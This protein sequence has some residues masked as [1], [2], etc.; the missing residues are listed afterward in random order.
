MAT[1]NNIE[2]RVGVIVLLAIIVLAGSLYWLQGYRLKL[3]SQMMTVRF[4]D[5]GTL[6]VGDKITV[7]G[8]RKGKVDD[9]RLT[10]NGVLVRLQLYQD[11]VLRRD[12]VFTI[13]N[14]GVM[15]DRFVAINP[16]KDSVLYDLNRV[17]EGRYDTG[18]PEVM[19]MMGDM[20]TQLHEL[21]LSLRRTVASD[22]ALRSFNNTVSNLESVSASMVSYVERHQNSF[23]KTAENFVS[24]SRRLDDLLARSDAPVDST[25]KRLDRVSSEVEV[26]VQQ[27]DSVAAAARRFADRVEVEEGTLQMLVEDRSLYDDLRRTADN[28]DDLI[29]D[30]RA[31]PRKYINLKVELF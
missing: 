26:I 29:A 13:K 19:G 22:S 25:L 5:V 6:S 31:N 27:L 14:L 4:D 1:G 15:G 9:L 11:V 20:V 30:I 28:L 21:V 16:G 2:F 18:I 8:V 10:E 3:N 23:D 7:S 12:A 17:A 24:A